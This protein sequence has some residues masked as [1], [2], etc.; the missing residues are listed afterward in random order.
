MMNMTMFKKHMR[1][2]LS[3]F[4]LSKCEIENCMVNIPYELDPNDPEKE[5]SKFAPEPMVVLAAWH[6][7][8]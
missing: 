1:I 3:I 2:V 6:K 7:L 4:S 8:S 5:K